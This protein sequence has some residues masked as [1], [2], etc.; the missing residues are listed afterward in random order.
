MKL[1]CFFFSEQQNNVTYI[2]TPL[3]HKK[4]HKKK[5]MSQPRKHRGQALKRILGEITAHDPVITAVSPLFV[6]QAVNL[7]LYLTLFVTLLVAIRWYDPKWWAVFC[8]CWI[9]VDSVVMLA[10]WFIYT[11][12]LRACRVLPP[13]YQSGRNA[14]TLVIGKAMHFEIQFG[15]WATTF[16]FSVMVALMRYFHLLNLKYRDHIDHAGAISII[17]ALIT[18]SLVGVVA[19]FSSLSS[20]W[21]SNANVQDVIVMIPNQKS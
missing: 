18:L 17:Q 11:R 5:F 3:P 15:V 4:T 1:V 21:W 13:Q 12:W 16:I 7:V 20:Q 2:N 19:L 6:V 14:N 8:I 10:Q 9:V